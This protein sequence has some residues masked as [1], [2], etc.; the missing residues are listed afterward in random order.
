MSIY[1]VP[2]VKAALQE[3]DEGVNKACPIVGANDRTSASSH[4]ADQR[5]EEPVGYPG[6]HPIALRRNGH[7][8]STAGAACRISPL[9]SP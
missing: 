6:F 2:E 7:D 4:D 9:F 8:S 1:L 5:S 3:L